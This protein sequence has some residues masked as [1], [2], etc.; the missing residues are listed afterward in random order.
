M[1]LT[2]DTIQ[3]IYETL[4]GRTVSAFKVY[5]LS[6]T[7][8]HAVDLAAKLDLAKDTT[9][10]FIAINAKRSWVRKFAGNADSEEEVLAWLDAVRLGDGAREKLPGGLVVEEEEEEKKK[11][12]HDEL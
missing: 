6:A 9:T 1:E 3:N 4:T 7:S 8:A 11:E 12:K 5:K 10:K 2:S